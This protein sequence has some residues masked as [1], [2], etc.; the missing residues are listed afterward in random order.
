VFVDAG[1]VVDD[2]R[3]YQA[4]LGYGAGIRWA[5]PLGPLNFDLAYGEADATWRV[6]FSVGSLF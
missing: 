1:N 5:S 3:D 4:K 6:N 2:I